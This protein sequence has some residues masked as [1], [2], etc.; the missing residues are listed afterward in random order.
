M[1]LK[2]AYFLSAFC[3]LTT[4]GR[5]RTLHVEYASAGMNFTEARN[6][7]QSKYTDL[8]TEYNEQ[9]NK[10]L[11]KELLEIPDWQ[12]HSVKWSDGAAVTF[13]KLRGNCVRDCCAAMK[14]DKEWDSV[15]CTISKPFVC[16]D[17]GNNHL[18]F[19][20]YI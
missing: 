13:F 4:A 5:L 1:L 11:V 15:N 7:C 20:T 16:F 10:E 8:L 14:A 9:I 17:K 2:T 18:T 6:I 12:V 3:P 19:W